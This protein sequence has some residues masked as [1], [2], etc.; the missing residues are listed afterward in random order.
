M[1]LNN[2]ASC[3]GTGVMVAM[4]T[5]FF[6]L[7]GAKI[8]FLLPDPMLM[9]QD[10]LDTNIDDKTRSAPPTNVSVKRTACGPGVLNYPPMV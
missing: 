2:K 1:L 7:D 5:L 9:M 10:E 8:T 3:E 6:A 4:S